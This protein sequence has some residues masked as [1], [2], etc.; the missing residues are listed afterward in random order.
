MKSSVER[1]TF[2]N[3][4]KLAHPLESRTSEQPWISMSP[5]IHVI[6]AKRWIMSVQICYF[7]N[8]LL[9]RKWY[10]IKN[11]EH[12]INRQ[13]DQ[14]ISQQVHIDIGRMSTQWQGHSFAFNLPL[15]INSKL[16][17]NNF[18]ID[19]SKIFTK[20]FDK[21]KIPSSTVQFI[22]SLR[23][24]K[25]S[26]CLTHPAHTALA[27]LFFVWMTD[28]IWNARDHSDIQQNI[29]TML[30]WYWLGDLWTAGDNILIANVVLY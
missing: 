28:S 29:M 24:I 19:A 5:R 6:K 16:N 12:F 27:Q 15:S 26:S 8:R 2:R 13:N 22:C 7:A 21:T 10:L 11:I 23:K 18:I 25:A 9:I 20:Y 1:S 4:W 30:A 14:L 17:I 3:W